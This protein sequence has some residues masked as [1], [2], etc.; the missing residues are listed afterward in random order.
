MAPLLRAEGLAVRYG[1]V[2][3]VKGIDLVVRQGEAVTIVGANGAGKSSLLKA[4]A[5]LVP[6][7]GTL[8]FDGR[9]VTREPAHRRARLGIALV[10]EGRRVFAPLTVAENLA[11]GGLHR[12]RDENRQDL[13]RIHA[14][15]PI[16]RERARQPAATLSGGEQQMLALGRALMQR[17]R[18]LLLDEPSL[19]LAPLVV[20]EI[21]GIVRALNEDDGLSVLVVEQNAIVAL[22]AAHRAYVLEVGR[23]AVSGTSEELRR[24]ESVR[25]SYLGY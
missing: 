24:D 18:L 3:A 25:R 2:E 22:A 10:P 21:F 23:V 13:E 12:T 8:S 5:G 17:P 9:D 7:R 20:R 16:L 15:F 4:I 1:A 6:G 11:V 19:G 14:L